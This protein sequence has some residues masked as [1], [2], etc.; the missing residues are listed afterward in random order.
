M[1]MSRAAQIQGLWA[2]AAPEGP[3]LEGPQSSLG[4]AA[5]GQPSGVPGDAAL[6]QP[7]G[8]SGDAAGMASRCTDIYE[9]NFEFVWRSLRRLG[10]SDES[11]DDATQE[12]FLV[13]FRRIAEF[14]GHSALRS[15]LFGIA[16]R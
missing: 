6:D 15:W 16:I 10:V 14:Q 11:L 5:L 7:S 8:I 9:Q 13:V 12:V 2:A 4:D 1:G 3:R